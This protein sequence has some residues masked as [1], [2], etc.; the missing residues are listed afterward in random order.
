MLFSK[1]KKKQNAR[2]PG[3][4]VSS[5]NDGVGAGGG[6]L[7]FFPHGKK[8]LFIRFQLLLFAITDNERTHANEIYR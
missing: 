5:S 1:E 3:E 8:T 6:F 7:F 4:D 2:I